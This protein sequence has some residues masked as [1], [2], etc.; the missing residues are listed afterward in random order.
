MTGSASWW[1]TWSCC[2]PAQ[3]VVGKL[4]TDHAEQGNARDK[5]EPVLLASH[6]F[7]PWVFGWPNPSLSPRNSPDPGPWPGTLKSWKGCGRSWG[8]SVPGCCPPPKGCCQQSGTLPWLFKCK[9]F[10][11]TVA[12]HISGR[13]LMWPVLTRSHT[14]KKVLENS[15]NLARL[16][17]YQI[18]RS[19]QKFLHVNSS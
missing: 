2:R 7:A 16:A 1:P 11:L 18:N 9:G 17:Q 8:S 14:E 10:H 13:L 4:R 5:P 3:Q 15:S 19:A 6:R 12:L